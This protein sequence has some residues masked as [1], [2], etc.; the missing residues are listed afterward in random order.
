MDDIEIN[1]PFQP[2]SKE[3]NIIAN[4][5][6]K[7]VENK[8]YREKLAME[9]YEFMKELTDPY[10][11]ASEWDQLFEKMKLKNETI[12]KKSLKINQISK[13]ITFFIANGFSFNQKL[14]KLN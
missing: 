7:T 4:I 12:E 13:K 11:T 14:F 2:T 9:E 1:S 10:K 8:E 6:D 3:P 5:I